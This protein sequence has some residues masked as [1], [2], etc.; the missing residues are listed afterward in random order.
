MILHVKKIKN[1]VVIPEKEF[2]TILEI[3][4]KTEHIEIEDNFDDLVSASSSSMDFWF[5]TI[6]DEV[7]N[8]A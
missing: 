6:D 8:N 3:I 1:N 7:W 5:N 4:K 2:I